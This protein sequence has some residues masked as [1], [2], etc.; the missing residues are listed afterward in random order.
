MSNAIFPALPGLGWNIK[1]TE[2]W[3]TRVQEAISGKEVRIADW[4][5]PRHQWELT[6]DFLRSAPSFAEW[7]SLIGFFDLRQG[8]FDS[9]LYGDADD[10]AVTDQPIGTGDGTTTIFQLVRALGGYTE[11]MIATNVV[12][13]IKVA[14]VVQGGGTYSV[15][16]NTGLATF[17]AS[18]ASGAAITA[19]FS[20]YFRCRFSADSVD[21]EKFMSQL[22]SAK[23]VKFLSLKSA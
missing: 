7:Q 3:K 14:G 10:N 22:W 17:T 12:T 9:F 21:F 18:P 16:A 4:S 5:F 6:F 20:Y 1:R 8:A 15:D 2:I 13:N 19:S 23:S 11:P